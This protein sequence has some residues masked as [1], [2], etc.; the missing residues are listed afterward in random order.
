MYSEDRLTNWSEFDPAWA[1]VQAVYKRFD[2]RISRNPNFPKII[3]LPTME[4]FLRC[5]SPEQ[6]ETKL[7][8]ISPEFIEGL[9]AVFI[10]GGTQKQ[11]KSW[12]SGVT[13]Y[14]HYWRSCVFLH[15]C[16]AG[17]GRY[18]LTE[19]RTFFISDV[20]V[21]EIGHHVDKRHTT[22]KERERFA[23]AFA[24]QNA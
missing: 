1:E 13:T 6:V 4:G 20:L 11:L 21:H 19:S 24:K 14:G 10:L 16:P 3:A 7:R 17:S 9:R 15:A 18:S 8:Q 22:T 12:G 5:C 2:H 23:E